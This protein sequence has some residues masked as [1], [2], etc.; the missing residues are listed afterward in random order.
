MESRSLSKT[1]GGGGGMN[2]P[3]ATF[4]E[5]EEQRFGH[6][7]MPNAFVAK[8]TINIIKADNAIY[9]SCPTDNCKKKVIDQSNGMYKCEKC[10]KEYPNFNYRLLASVSLL[11]FL[12]ICKRECK[13]SIVY[14]LIQVNLVDW[15][16]NHWATAFNEE[17]EMMLGATAQE[18]GELKDGDNEAYL[19]KIGTAAFKSFIFRL[20]L[21]MENYNVCI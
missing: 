20:R 3:W 12:F 6:Q 18:L 16:G 14:Y 5:A 10:Q 17:A 1:L 7:D 21:R 15:S 11:N 19:E 13:I 8:A 4:K 2:G 9:K